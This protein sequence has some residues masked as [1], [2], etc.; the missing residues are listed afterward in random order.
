M[1]NEYWVLDAARPLVAES[2]AFRRNA[3]LIDLNAGAGRGRLSEDDLLH[4]VFAGSWAGAVDLFRAAPADPDLFAQPLPYIGPAAR[5][6]SR[7]GTPPFLRAVFDATAAARAVAPARTEIEFLHDVVRASPRSG[8]DAGGHSPARRQVPGRCRRSRGTGDARPRLRPGT[9]GSVLRRGVARCSRQPDALRAGSRLG[10][11]PCS[12]T[13]H[14]GGAFRGRPAS[15][16]GR[17][18][19]CSRDRVQEAMPVKV[20][21][22]GNQRLRRRRANTIPADGRQ[23]NVRQSN[24]PV[25]VPTC[26]RPAAFSLPPGRIKEGA[27]R[28]GTCNEGTPAG[29]TKRQFRGGRSRLYPD[30]FV[31]FRN[32]S[33]FSIRSVFTGLVR[34]CGVISAVSSL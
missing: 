10:N 25:A 9:R 20:G 3:S 7:Y 2:M 4:H 21:N 11:E 33:W 32:G 8:H 13:R 17:R 18:R 19:R 14:S 5:S 34:G 24:V 6:E 16:T 1:T 28:L 26:R 23:S 27:T 15:E 29:A 31:V 30:P 22:E 12:E